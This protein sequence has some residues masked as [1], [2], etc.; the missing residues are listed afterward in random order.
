M[1]SI[2]IIVAVFVSV[3]IQAQKTLYFKQKTENL[4]NEFVG[5][6]P[7]TLKEVTGNNHYQFEYNKAGKLVFVR[8]FAK[9]ITAF[10]NENAVKSFMSRLVYKGDTVYQI[11][12]SDIDIATTSDAD[13]ITN[14]WAGD[15]SA[16]RLIYKNGKLFTFHNIGS[17][18]YAKNY[19][20][21]GDDN[22][23]E[24]D[25]SKAQARAITVG[26]EY[27]FLPNSSDFYLYFLNVEG[28]RSPIDELSKLEVK[29]DKK[30]MTKTIRYMN[31]KN[32]RIS[33]S[34]GVNE[35]V[36]GENAAGSKCY[37][38]ELNSAGEINSNEENAMS[39]YV[40]VLAYDNNG[41]PIKYTRCDKNLKPAI[42][43]YE[44]YLEDPET[45]EYVPT[46][47]KSYTEMRNVVD[48]NG[49]ILES[50]TFDNNGVK[51]NF[52]LTYS[53]TK[54]TY[55]ANGNLT[56]VRWFAANGDL[57]L[58]GSY[59][60]NV[61]VYNEESQLME[62][63]NLGMDNKAA[64]DDQGIYVR[65]MEYEGDQLLATMFYDAE[66]AQMTDGSGAHKYV[67]GEI[68]YEEDPEGEFPMY[69]V[70]GLNEEFLGKELVNAQENYEDGS[71]V[72]TRRKF[73]DQNRIISEKNFDA[74]HR[75]YS[76]E[77]MT[78]EGRYTYFDASEL[79]GFAE[80]NA[81]TLKSEMFFDVELNPTFKA[82]EGYHKLER[83][84][85]MVGS[86]YLTTTSYYNTDGSLITGDM[87]AIY[88]EEKS[89]EEGVYSSSA[90]ND[91]NNMPIVDGNGIWKT[92]R[93]NDINTGSLSTSYFDKNNKPTVNEL[94][95]HKEVT[96]VTGLETVRTFL[97]KKGKLMNCTNGYAKTIE[98]F[99]EN[100]ATVSLAYYN[101]KGKAV[102][103][104]D[105]GIH[106][107]TYVYDEAGNTIEINMMN[108]KGK[109]VDVTSWMWPSG[110]KA[111][112]VVRTYGATEEGY[113]N[114]EKETY[115][116]AKGDVLTPPVI[117]E[118][119][120]GE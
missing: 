25:E 24:E 48:V 14:I 78:F 88:I 66:G 27:E 5:L 4:F 56:S 80:D 94:K 2:L 9:G 116:D 37:S 75:A 108:K 106:K 53:T 84:L 35:V 89:V 110:F 93:E 63:Y 6:Y 102:V 23:L 54:N 18:L 120:E 11:L 74:Q 33:I 91:A 71:F 86:H 65:K 59:T 67:L 43:I 70:Y 49:D 28:N 26:Y 31:E 82:Y 96:V 22:G 107:T 20:E 76:S 83:K 95:V 109:S 101:K 1:K 79:P 40:E 68:N 51:D 32:E 12:V 105:L 103:N 62:S 34:N 118:Y 81:N 111:A 104:K 50:S 100:Y 92:V 72:F 39:K 90:S 112:R 119:Y 46:S 114:L 15:V 13:I 29:T 44:V 64:A 30:L 47:A 17:Y 41:N 97:D 52:D 99:N 45:G 117:E 3:V 73:D 38:L 115:Y 85:E 113:Y 8:Q 98:I 77:T 69:D 10:T 61:N 7:T 57:A 58:N 42:V 55:D 36:I 16:N 60:G 21:N 19:L 87:A